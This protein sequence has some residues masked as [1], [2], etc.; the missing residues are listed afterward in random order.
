MVNFTMEAYQSQLQEKRYKRVS[1]LISI[2]DAKTYEIGYLELL[3]SFQEGNIEAQGQLFEEKSKTIKELKDAELE[4]ASLRE[5]SYIQ[6]INCVT[7]KPRIN[8]EMCD[9]IYPVWDADGNEI[10]M[11][12]V[13]QKG[14]YS[15]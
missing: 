6:D 11:F 14:F 4:L 10:G 9:R 8:M 13:D 3:I 15:F 12:T 7:S 5:I 1:E 2:I